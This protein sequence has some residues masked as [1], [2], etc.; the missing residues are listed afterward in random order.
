MLVTYARLSSLVA[1]L[2]MNF[3]LRGMINMGTQG[4]GIPFTSDARHALNFSPVLI[5]N[6]LDSQFPVQMFWGLLCHRRLGPVQPPSIR[7]C[8]CSCRR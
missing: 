4:V 6:F 8:M 5:E 3:M 2:G 1:T 7:R